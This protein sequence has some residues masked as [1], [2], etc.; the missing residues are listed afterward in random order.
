LLRAAAIS[1]IACLALYLW[2]FVPMLIRPRYTPPVP[3]PAE[4]RQAGT[5]LKPKAS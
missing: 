5:A 2:R 4:S 1:W 3:A